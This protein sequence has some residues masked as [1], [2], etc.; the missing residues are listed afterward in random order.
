MRFISGTWMTTDHTCFLI[1]NYIMLLEI[2]VIKPGKVRN[3]VTPSG[4]RVG[5]HRPPW[6][7]ALDEVWSLPLLTPQLCVH[8]HTHT[9]MSLMC[10]KATSPTST[11]VTVHDSDWLKASFCLFKLRSS[12]DLTKPSVTW[13]MLMWST[14][15]Q[16][17]LTKLTLTRKKR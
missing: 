9:K 6:W 16:W 5:W 11:W 2:K 15:T 10:F 17:I 1:G 14:L 13:W 4:H 8:T 3:P 12:L 7:D